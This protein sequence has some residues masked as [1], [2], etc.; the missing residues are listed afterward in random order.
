MPRSFAAFI[1][2]ASILLAVDLI[3]PI[4]PNKPVLKNHTIQLQS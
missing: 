4:A 1:L 3:Q 2:A